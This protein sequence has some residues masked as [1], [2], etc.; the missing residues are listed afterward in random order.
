M[1]VCVCVCACVCVCVR[2]RSRVCVCMRARLLAANM[3]SGDRRM[4][5]VSV[6][7]QGGGARAGGWGGGGGGLDG[8]SISTDARHDPSAEE[9]GGKLNAVLA[10]HCMPVICVTRLGRD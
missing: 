3:R 4:K 2:A 7:G 8:L 6:W 9:V 10:R 5:D 1:C